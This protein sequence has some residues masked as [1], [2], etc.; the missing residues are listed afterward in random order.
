MQTLLHSHI[1]LDATGS[2]IS[3][4][5]HNINYDDI[6]MTDYSWQEEKE[7]LEYIKTFDKIIFTDMSP[8]EEFFHELISLNKYVEIY[9]HHTSSAWCANLSKSEKY[10][11]FHDEKRSGSKLFFEEYILKQFPRVKKSERYVIELIDTYD[12]WKKKSPL[13][14][15]AQNFTR[16]LFK[17]LDWN[18]SGYASF[19]KFIDQQ[20]KKIRRLPEWRWLDGELKYIEQALERERIALE[21]AEARLQ[22]R[23][24]SKGVLFGTYHL[25]GKIS[26]TATKIL[27][28]HSDLKYLIIQNSFRGLNSSI[29]FRSRDE[30]EFN[31]LDLY[32]AHGH[33]EAAGSEFENNTKAKQFLEGD[34]YCLAYNDEFEE[35]EKVYHY[36]EEEDS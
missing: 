27:E 22:K 2:I 34:I 8:T 5:L 18:T 33:K 29:S 15:E 7:I 35:T 31:C 23:V 6:L 14:E 3:S 20:V 11:I 21:E 28:N 1:D 32:L 19:E 24:D 30:K 36:L 4:K 12:L 9:D 10:K 26:I 25:G 17:M 16:V 13:W